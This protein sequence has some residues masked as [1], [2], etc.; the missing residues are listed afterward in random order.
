MA[1]IQFALNRTIWKGNDCTQNDTGFVISCATSL[2]E[3]DSRSGGSLA[4][5]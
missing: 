2:K 4:A 5:Q 3:G 1:L